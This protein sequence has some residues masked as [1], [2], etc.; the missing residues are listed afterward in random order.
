MMVTSQGV[1]TYYAERGAGAP[2]LLLHGNPDS[3]EM[4]AGVMERLEGRWRCLAPDLP[5]FGHSQAPETFDCELETM[6]RWVDGFLDALAVTE[7]VHLVVHDFGGPYGLAWAVR[8]PERVRSLAISNTIFF[9]DYKWHRWARVWRTPVLGELSMLGMSW[10]VFRGAILKGSRKLSE[11][12]IRR[13]YQLQSGPMKAMVLRLYRA[14]DPHKLKG[15][16]KKLL[17]LTARVPAWVLWGEHD[18]Y[19]G[20]QF[21]ERFGAERVIRYA[22]SGHWAPAEVPEEFAAH[23]AELFTRQ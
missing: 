11:A 6:A 20:G 23:L 18:P 13:M 15:W 9:P 5:G 12:R 7:P 4:W 2:V 1:E 8:H 21:A 19:I 3:S 16:D 14:M 22:E 17:E 10:P